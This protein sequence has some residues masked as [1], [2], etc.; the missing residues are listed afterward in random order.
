[1]A[2]T[3][4]AYNLI[5][6][7]SYDPV[8]LNAILRNLVISA[9]SGSD[10]SSG[11]ITGTNI[12]A[13]T[14]T[15]GNIA[16]DAIT[17]V[18]IAADSIGASHI[19]SNSI[20]ADDIQ[21]DAVTST[22]I[23]A[24]SIT[25]EKLYAGAVTADKITVSSLDAISASLG[26]VTSGTVTAATVRTSSSPSASR[27]IMDGS[28]LRGYDS[29]LGATFKI[30]TDGTAPIFASGQ[31][32]SSIILDTTIISSDF[33]SSSE[34]PWVEVTDSGLAYRES[35]GAGMY[36]SGV[37]Y[38]DGSTYGV[39]VQVYFG[40][41]SRP[42]VSVELERSLADIRLYNRSTEPS[43][44]AL[45]GDLAVVS[46]TLRLCTT[47]GTPGTYK[48]FCTTD[49]YAP[50]ASPT[51]TGTVVLPATT[52]I[53]DVSATELGYI[54]GVTSAVQTQLGDKAPLA[55]PTFTGTVVIPTPFTLGAVSVTAN[56]DELNVL[57]GIPATLTAT[58]LGYVDGVTSAIQT[59]IDGKGYIDRGDP[60]GYDFALGD[61]TT[62]GN[63][64][65]LDLSS[66]VPAGAKAVVLRVV[67]QDDAVA[68][69]VSFRKN[70]NANNYSMLTTRT[71]VADIVLD[72]NYIVPCDT[73]RVIEY[74]TTAT[75]LSLLAVTIIGWFV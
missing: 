23:L 21:S 70:G 16:S 8:L 48:T 25:T 3:T 49:L 71:Q 1:M 13:L 45:I 63:W 42:C 72:G 39:G 37:Q 62:D 73:G 65:D 14:I 68:S 30:P 11:T 36:G 47:A 38:G 59:Q 4:P 67:I 52:S 28:G 29:T 18:K 51:F 60:T 40:N 56:G 53:G 22:K 24:G 2:T 57:D 54:N 10:I 7:E 46:G 12:A 50:L 35:G 27:V 31:I 32:Q 17:G 33:K 20:S 66:I 69:V 5:V 75:T 9:I 64:H 58:E 61:F 74:K 26:E 41:V 19:A 6:G 55:S 34:L 44:A 43:G 15:A